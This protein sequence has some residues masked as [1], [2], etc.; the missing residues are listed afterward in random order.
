VRVDSGIRQGST[1]TP[2]YDPMLAKVISS[3]ADREQARQAL[4]RGLADFTLVGVGTNLQFLS[5]ILGHHNFVARALT[6]NYLSET[7][8]GDWQNKTSDDN[9]LICA[10]VASVMVLEQQASERQ[11][12]QQASLDQH[13]SPWQS[14]GGFRVLGR[15]GQVGKTRINLI[16]PEDD[17]ETVVISGSQGSYQSQILSRD[18]GNQSSHGR[19][20][21]EQVLQVEIDGLSRRLT[22]DFL[23][24]EIILQWAGQSYRYQ[25]LSEQQ[26]ALSDAANEGSGER[27]VVATLPG[28]VTEI[29]VSVGDQVSAGDTLVVL[30]SMKLLH[31]L[32]AQTDGTVQEIFCAVGESVD[33]GAVLI[34]LTPEE[35]AS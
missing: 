9:L 31:N 34:E 25:Q 8:G 30:D 24:E 19:W 27:N 7:F 20:L 5:S 28:Q 12:D 6:T 10:A 29:K 2:Y 14:L 35:P 32:N 23:D 18:G 17:I 11:P 22:V 21:E 26:L 1:I 13:I 33:G 15:S 3:G 4:L 16:T